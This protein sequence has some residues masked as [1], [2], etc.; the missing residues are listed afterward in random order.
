MLISLK[1][2]VLEDR[3]NRL[4]AKGEVRGIYQNQ[5]RDPDAAVY[6]ENDGGGTLNQGY[7]LGHLNSNSWKPRAS[8]LS[9]IF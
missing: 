5:P 9:L 6:G 3:V 7:W 4:N 1:L 8:L 2:A